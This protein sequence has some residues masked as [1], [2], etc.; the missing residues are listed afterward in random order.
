LFAWAMERD[1][2][3]SSPCPALS[4]RSTLL[5]PKKSRQRVLSDDE[6]KLIWRAT[7]ANLYP[8]DPFTRL[9]LI[10]GCRRSELAGARWREFDLGKPGAET[11]TLK[12][13]RTKSG[14]LRVVPLPAM[15]VQMIRDLPHFAGGDFLFAASGGKKHF[16]A[17]SR[18]KATLNDKI[19]KLNGVPLE[20][21]GLHDLRRS[22]RTALSALSI[23][24]LVAELMVGHKQ[25]GIAAVYDLHRYEAEQ[26]EGFERWCARL[27]DIVTP[28]PANVYKLPAA[29]E[30][31]L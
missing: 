25:Q 1:I 7:E 19:T 28:A 4:K 23:P 21:W 3:G 10:L 2:I 12:G 11:W 31:Q 6:I 5:A 18:L 15:A 16:S 26:R 24:P 20:Q 30:A 13:E 17:Y 27:R 22:M 29:A 9:L 8:A 14:D